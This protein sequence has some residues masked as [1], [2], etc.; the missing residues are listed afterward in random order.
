M[1]SAARLSESMEGSSLDAANCKTQAEIDGKARLLLRNPTWGDRFDAV[2]N[3]TYNF[4][5][6]G[7]K[8]ML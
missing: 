5:K 1:L 2:T 7:D 8:R 3:F 6:A 4:A